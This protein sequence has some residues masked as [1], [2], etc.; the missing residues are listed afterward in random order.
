MINKARVF[1]DGDV[2]IVVNLL[3]NSTRVFVGTQQIGLLQK[4]KLD[5]D[6]NN[7]AT[8]LELTFPTSN[9]TEINSKVE[10]TVRSVKQQLTWAKINH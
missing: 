2:T 9:D 3:S 4:L 5:I 7:P 6:V 1:G 10:E 8:Q